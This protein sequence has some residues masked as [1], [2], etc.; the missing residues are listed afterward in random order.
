MKIFNTQDSQ[1]KPPVIMLVYGE[2]G[3]GKTTFASTAPK[4]ILADCENGAKYFGLRGISIDV[5]QIQQWSDMKEFFQVAKSGDYETIVIDPI[6]ELMEKLANFMKSTGN[7]KLVQ[8]DGNPTMAGWGWL[9]QT[10]RQYLKLLR[11]SGKHILIVAHVAEKGDEDRIL[12]RP[13]IMTKLSEELINM[14]DIVGYMTII[15]DGEESKRVILVDPT[16]DK[17][18]AKDRTG[19]LGAIIPPDFKQIIK[20]VQGTEKYR[21]SNPKAVVKS[22]QKKTVTTNKTTKT[23]QQSAKKKTETKKVEKQEKEEKY[24]CCGC[25]IEITKS[26]YEISTKL[27]QDGKSYCQECLKEYRK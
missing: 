3:V 19:Q 1:M 8:M 14:V 23:K 20:A 15:Q 22:N 27:S 21:W 6:G 24:Y 9:K 12:K 26:D 7:R 25:D 10:M 4:P 5:A 11:D 16:S 17:F 2:G 18:V 13:L